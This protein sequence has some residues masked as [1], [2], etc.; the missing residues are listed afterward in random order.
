MIRQE[1]FYIKYDHGQL[2]FFHSYD[3]LMDFAEKNDFGNGEVYSLAVNEA[4]IPIF[5]EDL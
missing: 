4:L 1:I 3:H 2:V 5:L